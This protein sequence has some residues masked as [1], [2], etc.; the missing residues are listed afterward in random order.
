MIPCLLSLLLFKCNICR[1]FTYHTIPF[2]AIFIQEAAGN[3][4]GFGAE[5]K[6]KG[7]DTKGRDKVAVCDE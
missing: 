4:S 5:K 3:Y 6:V 7:R 1:P 2:S